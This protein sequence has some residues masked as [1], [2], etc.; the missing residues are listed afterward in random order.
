MGAPDIIQPHGEVAKKT[1]SVGSTHRGRE[2][3]C[4]IS[5][6]RSRRVLHAMRGIGWN[7]EV[8][9]TDLRAVALT[10][11]V[12]ERIGAVYRSYIGGVANRVLRGIERI[13]FSYTL[14]S[15]NGRDP[16]ENQSIQ[17][18]AGS[19]S[20]SIHAVAKWLH[21]PIKVV[22]VFIMLG[23]GSKVARA[24]G[25]VAGD[26]TCSLLRSGV[27]PEAAL[28]GRERLIVRYERR[29]IGTGEPGG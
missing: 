3:I 28:G 5:G 25:T 7:M 18:L 14:D 23:C 29:G 4:G 13:R 20:Q 11:F 19:I 24:H 27:K 17:Q 22:T 26:G 8:C 9:G 10:R 16:K 2:R 21:V 15:A 1:G 12:L 6:A